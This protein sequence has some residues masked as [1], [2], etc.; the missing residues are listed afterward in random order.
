MSATDFT[1]AFF[2]FPTVVLFP[3][4]SS[5]V[6][7]VEWWDMWSGG[8]CG[9][10]GYGM[11]ICG[12]EVRFHEQSGFIGA[13][14]MWYNA[15]ISEV[16]GGASRSSICTASTCQSL[17]ASLVSPWAAVPDTIGAPIHHSGFNL[18]PD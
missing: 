15:A 4:L 1:A 9:V 10:V 7:Y 12:T 13:L 3:L 17:S 18:G 8:I 6:G 16:V 14:L 11:W 2:L 5:V